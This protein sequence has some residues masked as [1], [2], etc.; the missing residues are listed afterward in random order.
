[1]RLRHQHFPRREMFSDAARRNRSPRPAIAATT[2]APAVVAMARVEHP[3]ARRDGVVDQPYLNFAR[4]LAS[5]IMP[6]FQNLSR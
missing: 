4:L 5:I 1:M 3:T 6:M 2:A